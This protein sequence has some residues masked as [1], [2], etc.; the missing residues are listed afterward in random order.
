MRWAYQHVD[1]VLP[2]ARIAARWT[3]AASPAANGETHRQKLDTLEVRLPDDERV[4]VRDVLERTDTDAW[5][6]LQGG[7]VVVEEYA[8]SMNLGTRH[9]LQSVSK[10]VTATVVGAL[11]GRAVVDPG[12]LVTDYVPDLAGSGYAGAAV[13]HLLDMRSG[14]GF[15]EDYDHARSD[16]RRLEASAGWARVPS[17]EPRSMRELLVALRQVRPHGGPFEYRSCE[18]AV[19]GW[20]CQSATG[21]PFSE[22]ASDLVWSRLGAQDDAYITVDP[23]GMGAFDGGICVTAGDLARFGAMVVQG[24]RSLSGHQVVPRAWVDD[25]FTGADD[26]AEV[27]ASSADGAPMPGGMYRSQFWSP[28]SRR[29]LVVGLGIHGQMVFMDRATGVVGAKLSTWPRPEDP[30]KQ[31]ATLRMFDAVSAHLGGRP[32]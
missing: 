19:L 24:G 29:D 21:T 11:V 20:V 28:S 32:R 2:T 17:G 1:E 15:V 25:V 30:W 9:L 27:F 26:S 6:V 5:V 31:A 8:G 3:A 23:E 14:V 16:S 13:R 12:A 18:T 10:S 22:L 7:Q 4:T